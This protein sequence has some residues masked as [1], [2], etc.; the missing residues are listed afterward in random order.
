MY[1]FPPQAFRRAT[2][3][4]YEIYVDPD[5]TVYKKFNLIN[6]LKQMSNTKG[7]CD[8]VSTFE[9]MVNFTS[10]VLYIQIH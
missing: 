6:G 2:G 1:F 7:K 9:N 4:T 3:C 8:Q 10:N 5:C